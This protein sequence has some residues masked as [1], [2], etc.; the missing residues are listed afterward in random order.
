ME[1]DDVLEVKNNSKV[2]YCKWAGT[3]SCMYIPITSIG[4]YQINEYKLENRYTYEFDVKRS[5]Y[6]TIRTIKD[7]SYN[8]KEFDTFPEA[9]RFLENLINQIY[10]PDNDKKNIAVT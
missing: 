9:E 8:L 5:Y 6:I 7:E 2:L 1:K 4:S 3:K 10:T